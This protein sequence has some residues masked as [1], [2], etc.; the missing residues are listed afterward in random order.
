MTRDTNYDEMSREELVNLAGIED[1]PTLS[2]SDLIMLAMEREG[3][4]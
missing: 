2:R 4:T 3:Q 1:D